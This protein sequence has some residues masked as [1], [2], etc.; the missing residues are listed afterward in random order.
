MRFGVCTGIENINKAQNMGF[1]YI[2]V[3][4][5]QIALWSES[6][7]EKNAAAALCANISCEASSILFPPTISFFGSNAATWSEIEKYLRNLFKRLTLLGCE[8]VVFGSGRCRRF[9]QDMSF[10][11]AHRRFAAI[12]SKMGEIA[13]EYDLK[14]VLESLNPNETNMINTVAE[15]AVLVSQIENVNLLA[16]SFHMFI[17]DEPLD[18]IKRVGKLAHVH[19][20][21]RDG[22]LYPVA[23]DD[24]LTAFFEQLAAIGYDKRVSIEA[25]TDNFEKDAPLALEI[26]RELANNCAQDSL[27]L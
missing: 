23:C 18:N 1:D 14:L 5:S 26:L 4:A 25:H 24:L 22:R 6:E 11:E 12:T 13:C 3:N 8:I 15:G 10:F 20:A 9:P 7:F 17:T 19:V 16:D 2:E 21:T 27:K